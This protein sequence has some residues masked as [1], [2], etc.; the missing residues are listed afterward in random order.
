MIDKDVFQWLHALSNISPW[1]DRVILYFSNGFGLTLIGALFVY[2]FIKENKKNWFATGWPIF[3]PAT[4]AFLLTQFVKNIYESPRPFFDDGL[5][6]IFPLFVHGGAD[7]FPSGHATLYMALTVS[8]FFY[9]KKIGV[10]F[11]IGTLLIT[12]SRVIAG[13]HWPSDILAGYVVGASTVL[14]YRYIVRRKAKKSRDLI[15]S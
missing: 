15:G 14:V 10:V 4:I 7:S 11:L 1:S 5:S 12:V 6:D 8:V 13:V 2:I 3:F 9:N